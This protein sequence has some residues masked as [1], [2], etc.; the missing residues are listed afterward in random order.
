M[1]ID[2]PVFPARPVR[3]ERWVYTAVSSGS[4][5][6]GYNADSLHGDLSQQQRDMVMKKFRDR[7]ITMLVATD[8]A[9]RGLDV[10][11]LT[12]VINYGLPDVE[13]QVFV[14]GIDHVVDVAHVGGAFVAGA[15]NELHHLLGQE[16]DVVALAQ[17]GTGKTAAFGLPVLQ[18]VDVSLK[19][20]SRKPM[21]SIS[22]AS[23]RITVCTCS[24]L[25]TLRLI[26]SMRRPGVATTSPTW[27]LKTPCPYRKRLSPI[28]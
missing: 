7:V 13:R 4:P 23:S 8:V 1:A 25:T 20:E 18:R 26:R 3:P 17:T 10:D 21:L 27:V 22:S 28:F 2:T 9:A 19:I 15:Y 6:D 5:C 14:A 12:H 16:G 24:R 11:D